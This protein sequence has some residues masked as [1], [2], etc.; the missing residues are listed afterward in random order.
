MALPDK[1]ELL[2][3]VPLDPQTLPA[4]VRRINAEPHTPDSR[5]LM[6]YMTAKAWSNGSNG[7]GHEPV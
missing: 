5:H 4:A 2:A 6:Y 7:S 1:L 3:E